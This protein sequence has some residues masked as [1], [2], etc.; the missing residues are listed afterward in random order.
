MTSYRDPLYRFGYLS[1]ALLISKIL[2]DV[3]LKFD[4]SLAI[5]MP[6]ALIDAS[7]KAKHYSYVDS[8]IAPPTPA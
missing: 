3:G 4:H 6:Y 7:V 8:L 2:E 1:F 5:Q